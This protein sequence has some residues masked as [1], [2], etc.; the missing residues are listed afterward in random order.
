MGGAGPAARDG[1]LVGG[2]PLR[3]SGVIKVSQKFADVGTGR[4]EGYQAQGA[5]KRAPGW[6]PAAPPWLIM[7]FPLPDS[8]HMSLFVCLVANQM[9][10]GASAAGP[11]CRPCLPCD[12][13]AVA[14]LVYTYPRVYPIYLA[15]YTSA[16][17]HEGPTTHVTRT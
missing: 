15:F 6:G 17:R 1:R 4:S 8:L 3:L 12:C 13:R 7:F 14:K 11:L 16:G 10:F 2:S 9:S 5:R